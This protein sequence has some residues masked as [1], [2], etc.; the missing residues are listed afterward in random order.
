MSH[1]GQN[2][3]FEF[4][5]ECLEQNNNAHLFSSTFATFILL[6]ECLGFMNVLGSIRLKTKF[7]RNKRRK[8]PAVP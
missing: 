2:T 7:G 4:L 6:R 8:E 5:N 1:G 3:W